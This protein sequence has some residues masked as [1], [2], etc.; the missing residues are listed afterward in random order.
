MYQFDQDYIVKKLKELLAI[1]STTGYFRDIQ[2]YLLNEMK[3]LDYPFEEV[4]KGGL[5]ADIGGEG[6]SLVIMAHGDD[7]G[8]M[9]RYIKDNGALVVTNV[10]GLRE[11]DATG[12]YCNLHTRNGDVYTGCVRRVHSCVHVRPESDNTAPLDYQTNMEFVLDEDVKSKQDVLN[13]GI[14]VG[15][16]IALDP[17]FRMNN[18]Y[19]TSRFLDDKACIAVLLGVMRY[20]KENKLVCKRNVKAFFTMFE[21]IGHGG[22]WLPEGTR[23]ILSLDI[24]PVAPTQVSNEKKVSLFA[25]DSRFPYHYEMLTE[26]VNAA[27]KIGAGYEVDVFTP[28]YG[29]DSDFAI[30]AGYNVRHAAIGPGTIG[31]HGYERT[32]IDSLNSMYQLLIEY[33]VG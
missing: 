23:D 33:M 15:D 22:A 13:L 2:N 11:E 24:A 19:I 16:I 17:G 14:R 10:G 8:L 18:G 29:T 21:E 5:I 27:E 32:H 4:H 7:I 26:L 9:V 6:D 30:A 28:R 3:E 31:S 25:K 1:D 20:I 12:V